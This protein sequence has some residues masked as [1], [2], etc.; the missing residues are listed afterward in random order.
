M[1]GDVTSTLDL[2]TTAWGQAEDT[3]FGTLPTLSSTK[4][5][6]GNLSGLVPQVLIL[7]AV[8]LLLFYKG[9]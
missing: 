5:P 6:S 1:L 2:N 8:G 7:I 9:R 3:L 4:V